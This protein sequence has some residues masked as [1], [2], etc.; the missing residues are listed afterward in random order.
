M[1]IF[2]PSTINVNVI[3]ISFDSYRIFKSNFLF[4]ISIKKVTKRMKNEIQHLQQFTRDY[5]DYDDYNNVFFYP[6]GR[7]NKLKLG[8][9]FTKGEQ[10]PEPVSNKIYNEKEMYLKNLMSKW[11]HTSKIVKNELNG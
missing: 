9:N 7:E 6:K 10:N 1:L 5:T 11:F 4:K 3:S 2:I 8:P